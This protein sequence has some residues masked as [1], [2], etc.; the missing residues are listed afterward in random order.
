MTILEGV[1]AWLKTCPALAGERLN[2]DYLPETAKSY[3]VEVVPCTEVVKRYFDGAAVKQF[4]FVLA[5]RCFCTDDIKQNT[6]NIAFY[7][8]FSRWVERQC[9]RRDFPALGE[10]R[11]S[12]KVEVTTSGYLFTLDDHGNARYQ[13]QMKL[14]Y[15]QKGQR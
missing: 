15:I 2:V 8:D 12:R 14:T 6:D 5:S 4:L 9:R 10:D 11:Q 1:R 7:E 13:I 3:S